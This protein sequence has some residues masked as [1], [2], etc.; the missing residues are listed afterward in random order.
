MTKWQFW[1]LNLAGSLCALL[2]AVNLTLAQM[3]VRLNKSVGEMQGR[4][5]QAQRLQNTAQSLVGRIAQASQQ[6]ASL[7]ELLVRHQV[8]FAP[9]SNAPAASPA[10]TAAVPVAPTPAPTSAPAGTSSP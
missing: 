4:F 5:G 7:R 8:A 3:N 2:I 1:T 6:D 10:P 9:G